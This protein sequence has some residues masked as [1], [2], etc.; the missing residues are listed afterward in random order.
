[1]FSTDP[2]I[3]VHLL[4]NPVR[5]RLALSS[6]SS[7]P[8]FG[9]TLWLGI[10]R[11]YQPMKITTLGTVHTTALLFVARVVNTLEAAGKRTCML[12]ICHGVNPVRH[13]A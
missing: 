11:H 7:P 3:S 12:L 4:N 6:R 9:V 1:M 5:V 2:K 10:Q 13:Y 8:G